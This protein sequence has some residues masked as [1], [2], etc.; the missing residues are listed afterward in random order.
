MMEKEKL[1]QAVGLLKELGL[2]AW[3]VVERESEISSDPIM[4]YIIGS[5]FTWLSFFLVLGNGQK[6]AIVGNL[7]IEKTERLGLFDRMI[8]Y[9]E[10]PQAALLD[11]LNQ[12]DPQT[13]AID[14]SLDSPVADGLSHG[15]FLQ[16]QTLLNG[17]DFGRR[18][19]SAEPLIVRLRGRKSAEEI[20]RMRRAIDITL[21]IYDQV[22]RHVKPGMTELQVAG[23]IAAWRDEYG[24]PPSWD[25]GHNPSVF[26]GPQKTG[27]HSGPTDRILEPGHIFNIDSGVMVD[28]YCSDLQRTWYILKEGES[29]A[30]DRVQ[31]GLDTIVESIRLAAQAMRPGVL[32]VDIDRIAR[33][34]IVSRGYDEFPH[35]LGHQVGRSAHDGGALLGPAW[36]RY[37]R[38]PFIPLEAGQVF[39][40]E[41]RLYLPDHGVATIEEMVLVKEDG[42]E[43]LSAPQRELYLINR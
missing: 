9:R 32:G 19:V 16:L 40:I 4:D 37:G 22:T 27:A 10:S 7:D 33:D 5:G 36:E 12:Y 2:D 39:T 38:L 34:Y 29:R 31:H 24:V 14:Y 35:A 26:T 30:P 18:L 3:L 17:S 13:I 15:C 20:R 28:R 1:Q 41:P 42:V 25:A 43:F 11:T 8:A 6:I 21:E 23:M